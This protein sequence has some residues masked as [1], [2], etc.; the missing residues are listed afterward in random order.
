V[1]I[2][3]DETVPQGGNSRLSE[4]GDR[5]TTTSVRAAVSLRLDS[6]SK[7]FGPVQALRETTLDVPAGALMALLGPSGCG[8]TTTLRVIAGF[9]TSD[10]GAVLID[11]R[12]VS[13]LPPNRR[14]LGMVFQNYSLFPHMTVGENIGFGLKMARVPKAEIGRRVADMLT[15]V[16]L[17]GF[18]DRFSH[19][20][21]G[22]QQQ[23]VA[24]ARALVTNPKVLLLDEPLGALD[25]NLRE[26]M[27]F[28]LRQLQRKLGITTILVTH[29]QEEALTVS[30]L[31]AVMNLGR[32]L[33]VGTPTD[34]YDRP[35]SRFVSEFLGTSNLF[36]ARADSA[37]GRV[38]LEFNGA[39]AVDVPVAAANGMPSGHVMLAVRPEKMA[40]SAQAPANGAAA[41]RG[42]VSGRVFRGTYH[43]YQ[44]RLA[45]RDDPVFV[46]QQP[47]LTGP[48][49]IFD[50]DAP[51]FITW[52][53][54]NAVL[55]QSDE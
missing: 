35:K 16:R 17:A 32:I 3:S 13:D 12:D 7:S 53:P 31:I 1:S 23:R 44:V 22:G 48:A 6:I 30:D 27:Q 18:E 41:L 20:L 42:I 38:R 25:K 46:Y 10:T 49:E 24:L 4:L 15:L 47:S 55:L 11:G 52:H 19:Q 39:G 9:E 36:A 2:L 45:G 8:K 14:N 29:D 50:V 21:S 40:L 51:V 43:A 28:E 33:Q 26:S 37:A 5:V 34:V 54:A